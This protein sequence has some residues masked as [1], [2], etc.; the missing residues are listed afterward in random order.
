MSDEQAVLYL[1]PDDEITT[2]ARRLRETDATRVVLVAP[3]RTRATTSATG[4]RLLAGLARDD[5]RQLV[6]VADPAARS[7]AAEA[8]IASAAT[9]AE[10]RAL[11]DLA[12][13]PASPGTAGARISVARGPRR[14]PP[15]PPP[16]S[17]AIAL[18]ETRAVP[19]A[20]EPPRAVARRSPRRATPGRWP[21]AVIAALALALVAAVALGA[22]VLPGATIR[23]APE[24]RPIDPLAYELVTGPDLELHQASG[25]APA[26]ATG[27]ATGVRELRVPATGVVRLQNWNT[28]AIEVGA[29]TQ[30]AAGEIVFTTDA[31][32]VVPPG[33]FTPD[34]RVQ[35]G[36][37]TVGVTAAA[38]GPAGNVAAEAIDTM[39]TEPTNSLLRG[40]PNSRLRVV[41]NPEATAGGEAA[42]LPVIQQADVDAV[43][44]TFRTQ[45]A[46]AVETART[47]D[48]AR[49]PL[50]PLDGEQVVDVTVPDGLVGRE[51]EASFELTG[52]LRWTVTWLDREELEAR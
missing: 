4:L 35:A 10:A 40:F 38:P 3:G 14:A 13:E 48:P 11:R 23:I 32:V 8:G 45:L 30:V 5:G 36:T 24:S 25:E 17:T 52:T 12:V 43:L 29:G 1:E 2:V 7:L 34:G 9:V 31:T 46:A 33:G 26:R 42:D 37:E 20:A 28:V 44:A 51:G 19:V 22:I 39:L 41:I 6:L 50:D 18:D 15:A 47:D 16:P 21:P 27:T 49:I